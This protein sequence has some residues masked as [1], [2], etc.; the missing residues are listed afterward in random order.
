MGP[1]RG[2]RAAVRSKVE[3]RKRRKKEKKAKVPT[4]AARA[5]TVSDSDDS[6][7]DAPKAK[8]KKKA[9]VDAGDLRAGVGGA[10][11]KLQHLPARLWAPHELQPAAVRVLVPASELG[12]EGSAAVAALR[13][14]LGVRVP[15]VRSRVCSFWL[16]GTCKRGE[17]CAFAH[18]D[19]NVNLAGTAAPCPP[20]IDGLGHPA[21]P[22][23]IGRA[24]LHLG[25][26]EPS[27]VQA[28]A[29]SVALSG[30]DLLCRAPTGS[31]KTLAYVLPAFCHV[32]A[33]KKPPT[34]NAGPYVLVLVPTR[35]LAMQVHGVCRGLRKLAGVESA[36]LYGGAPREEQVSAV[37]AAVGLVVATTG[38]LLDMLFTKHVAVGRVSLVVF[39]EADAMVSLGFAPQ[40]SQVCGQ[41]RPDRQTIL[42]SA[43]FPD[44]L[45]QAAAG[46]LRAPLRVYVD[47]AGGDE[48][49]AAAAAPVK[50]VAALPATVTQ[51]FL[52]CDDGR[53]R[54]SL[55]AF[56]ES[57]PRG[58]NPARVMVF[59]NQIKTI[60]ALAASLRK[61]GL[62]CAALH[63]DL[64]QWEREESLQRFRAGAAPVLVTT[65]VGARGLDIRQLPAVVSFDVPASIEQYVHRAGRTGRQ[66]AAGVALTLLRRD[67]ASAAFARGA[68]ALLQAGGVDVPAELA[69]LAS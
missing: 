51:S 65:D 32:L 69:A 2:G 52:I 67:A 5:S 68:V 64:A 21:L 42:F 9:K 37:E 53:R 36:A 56:L 19:S 39:D 45:E 66:G 1:V 49:S 63:G 54:E 50:A 4:P 48:E 60:K 29:W 41:L 44:A 59:V 57:L 24:M 55:R 25:H 10:A 28:Q 18:S 58:R 7:D 13:R 3:A 23:L 15:D 14:R 43:T 17:A 6:D 61:F 34:P 62:A 46:W 31:G 40:V 20:P 47:A 22:R 11:Q 16:K 35:E 26:R 38:R 33:Q 12:D 8:K 27:A 30:R